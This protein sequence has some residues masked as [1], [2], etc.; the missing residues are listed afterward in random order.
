MN[1]L[2]A[3]DLICLSQICEVDLVYFYWEVERDLDPL[4]SQVSW[5]LVL[6]LQRQLKL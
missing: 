2:E 3:Q 5:Q 6:H 4:C 1:V